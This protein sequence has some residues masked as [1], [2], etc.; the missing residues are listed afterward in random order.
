MPGGVAGGCGHSEVMDNGRLKSGGGVEGVGV[1]VDDVQGGAGG[2]H[3][4]TEHILVK[5]GAGPP[6]AVL[7]VVRAS[8]SAMSCC[9]GGWP[10]CVRCLGTVVD[11][12]S[13]WRADVQGQAKSGDIVNGNFLLSLILVVVVVGVENGQ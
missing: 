11:N 7:V 12:T 9:R 1:G 2:L 13:H 3:W 8:A 5:V 4:C 6:P 10:I